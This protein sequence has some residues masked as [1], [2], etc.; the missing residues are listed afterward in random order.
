MT[1]IKNKNKV[2]LA[3]MQAK[4]EWQLVWLLATMLVQM[5][6]LQGKLEWQLRWFQRM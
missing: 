2:Q 1:I 4:L 5:A 3:R 6:G